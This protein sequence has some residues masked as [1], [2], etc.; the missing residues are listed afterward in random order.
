M[1]VKNSERSTTQITANHPL[2]RELSDT[3]Q[4]TISR[5][6]NQQD[7]TG[8]F[9]LNQQQT[10]SEK[11]KIRYEWKSI[12]LYVRL[13]YGENYHGKILIQTNKRKEESNALARNH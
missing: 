2:L 6:T 11:I 13:K 10:V 12:G 1:K 9:K 3:I 4:A 8:Q 7:T 5:V